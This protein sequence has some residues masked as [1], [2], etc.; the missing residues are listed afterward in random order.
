MRPGQMLYHIET[1]EDRK[2]RGSHVFGILSK[3]FP[4]VSTDLE[5]AN[6]FQLLVAIVLSA[7]TT[8]VNVNKVTPRLFQRFPNAEAMAKADLKELESLVFSTGYYKN[9]A[10]NIKEMAKKLVHEFNA[11]VPQTMEE[12]LS[13]PGVGRKTANVLL[14]AGLGK[15]EGLVVDTHVYRVARRLAFSD[16]S[17]VSKVEEDLMQ[18]FKRAQWIE[19]SNLFIAHGRKVCVA[20][21]PKCEQCSIAALC[22]SAQAQLD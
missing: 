15:T 20:R 22:P 4:E 5:F 3:D 12:L 19:I 18:T 16:K 13:L 10:R 6:L 14:G 1:S 2:L 21:R 7:Q 17:S 9:K 8:D 11:Q